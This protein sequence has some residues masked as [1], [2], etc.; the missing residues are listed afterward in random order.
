MHVPRSFVEDRVEILHEAIREAGL[1]TL[2]TAGAGGLVVSH[3]PVSLEADPA[4][5]GRLVAHLAR[6][7]S[8]WKS[9]RDGG[10]AVAIVL[11]PDGYVSPSWYAT[12]RETGRV[13]PT[14]DYVAVHAHGT[15][16][17]FHDRERLLE[18]VARLTE[19]H[20]HARA[21]PW[22]VSDAPPGYVDGLLDGIVGVE[23][24]ITRLEGR[25]KA[26]QNKGEGDRRGVEAGL[27]EEGNDAMAEVVRE[28]GARSSR[29]GR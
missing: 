28:R 21:E 23:L 19:R 26:S 17:F 10:A 5:L 22:K 8:Q 27:R 3:V 4:P 7:N 2:V 18:L 20:E 15:V 24:T 25:W 1:A 14:W 16:R 6:A 12:K 29:R 9:T 13:V 11:G